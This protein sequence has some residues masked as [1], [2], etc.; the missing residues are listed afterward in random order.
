ML[1]ELKKAVQAFHRPG[2]DTK[3]WRMVRNAVPY[4]LPGEIKVSAPLTIYWSIN[5]VCN[6]FCKMCDVGMFNEQGMFFKNLRI[7]RKL[8]EIDIDVFKRAIDEVQHDRPF[9]AINSTEPLMYKPL[10]EAIE[11]C[12]RRELRTGV[13]TGAY[14]LPKQAEALAEAGLTRLSVSMDGPPEVHNHI[15]GRKDSFEQ[16]YAGIE[17]FAAA[18]RRRQ[19][20][21]EIYI[22][23]TITNMN[24]NRLV[25]FYKS[26][27]P[28]APSKINFAYMWFIDPATAQEHN[29]EYGNRY[30]VTESCYSEWIDPFA[31]DI[32]VLANEIDQLKGRPNVHFSP[33]FTREELKT[34]FH[35]PNEFVNPAGR[36]LAT[37]FFLQVLAD[38]SVIVYTRCHSKPMGNINRQSI[39]EIWNGP[40]VKNWRKFIQS[41]GKMPMC[42]RCDLVY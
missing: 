40:E 30:S 32:D 5:S 25:E 19:R 3:P 24:H 1:F 31:V 2:I 22:N 35:R 14:T 11:H 15:R 6:L 33:L 26:V 28:L 13:T 4:Y 36:C 41:V 21:F 42:K 38:G 34:Y 8:H 17:A 16:A 27:A 10:A 23:C 18:C 29:K 37:W 20:P 12:T 7:D 39:A 9:I